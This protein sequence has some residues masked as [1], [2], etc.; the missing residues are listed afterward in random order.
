MDNKLFSGVSVLHGCLRPFKIKVIAH[1]YL[2]ETCYYFGGVNT[3]SPFY[4]GVKNFKLLLRKEK[5]GNYLTETSIS[6]TIPF[7]QIYTMYPQQEAIFEML[8]II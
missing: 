8:W 5:T 1:K 4:Y 3:F 6:N 2:S 7:H